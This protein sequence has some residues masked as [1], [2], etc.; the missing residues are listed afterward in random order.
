MTKQEYE[1]RIGDIAIELGELQSQRDR[2]EATSLKEEEKRAAL[3][4]LDRKMSVLRSEKYQI[5]DEYNYQKEQE[6]EEYNK[7]REERILTTN[8]DTYEKRHEILTKYM[9]EYPNTEL[10]K[11]ILAGKEVDMNEVISALRDKKQTSEN[12]VTENSKDSEEPR[13]KQDMDSLANKMSTEE[14]NYILNLQNIARDNNVSLEEAEKKYKGE[15]EEK[16]VEEEPVQKVE[17]EADKKEESVEESKELSDKDILSQSNLQNEGAKEKIEQS[18]AISTDVNNNVVQTKDDNNEFVQLTKTD[19][20][21]VFVD[22][23]PDLKPRK[24]VAKIVNKITDLFKKSREKG[25]EVVQNSLNRSLNRRDT[26]NQQEIED[27]F[28]NK[29]FNDKNLM[30][31]SNSKDSEGLTTEN[32]AQDYKKIALT[33]KSLV[34]NVQSKDIDEQNI[35]ENASKINITNNM[36]EADILSKGI[37]RG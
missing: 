34:D 3:D 9:K 23:K 2:I 19:P 5:E 12:S 4:R 36:S 37:E 8:I 14:M 31:N 7:N 26:M 18:K 15:Q 24:L 25:K 10:T 16:P 35:E 28:K 1:D 20:R 13:L 6:K 33:D 21:Q 32:L 17:L 29:D 27:H 30:E 11:D 22:Q